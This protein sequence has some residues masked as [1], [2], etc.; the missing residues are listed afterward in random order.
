MAVITSHTVHDLLQA[1]VDTIDQ[2]PD[3]AIRLHHY[4]YLGDDWKRLV[5]PHRDACAY[6]ARLRYSVNDV[7]RIAQMDIHTVIDWYRRHRENTGAPAAPVH[8]WP[9]IEG[10]IDLSGLTR[11]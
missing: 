5:I 10:A 8:R 7:A 4:A 9:L 2:E 3:P 11:R 1:L 6:D